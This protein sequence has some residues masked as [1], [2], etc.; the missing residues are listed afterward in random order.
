MQRGDCIGDDNKTT[1]AA[2][3]RNSHNYRYYCKQAEYN[4]NYNIV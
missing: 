1:S 4:S 3:L 2:R